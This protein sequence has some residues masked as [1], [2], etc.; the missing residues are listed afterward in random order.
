MT[1]RATISITVGLSLL[2]ALFSLPASAYAQHARRLRGDTGVVTLGVG[3]VLRTTVNG[4]DGNDT[5]RVRFAWRKYAA[6]GCNADGVCRHV[7]QSEGAT[8]PVNVPAN[9]A[10]SF[11]VQGTGGNVRVSVFVAAGD[12]NGDFQIINTATGEVTSHNV[13]IWFVEGDF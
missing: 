9:E 4:Q 11:D 1:R 12:V 5:F 7:V 10:A 2:I 13:V 8:T 6:A 3:Q